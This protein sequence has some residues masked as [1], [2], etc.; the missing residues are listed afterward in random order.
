MLRS[1]VVCLAA[2]F[3]AAHHSPAQQPTLKKKAAAEQ[4]STSSGQAQPEHGPR[5]FSNDECAFPLAIAGSPVSFLQHANNATSGNA[6]QNNPGCQAFGTRR[7]DNDEWFL[8]RANA[9]GLA[10][11]SA[12]P[13]GGIIDTKAAVWDGS[14]CP[15]TA[16]LGCNDD[17]CGTRSEVGFDCIAGRPYLIQIGL[18]PGAEPGTQSWTVFGPVTP[19]GTD[20]CAS[21]TFITG[22]SGTVAT[23]TLAATNN[24]AD[25]IPGACGGSAS[26]ADIWFNYVA[27]NCGVSTFSFCSA[28]LG[29]ATYDTALEVYTDCAGARGQRIACNDDACGFSSSVTFPT[30]VGVSYRIRVSGFNGNV[31]QGTLGWQLLP[32]AFLNGTDDCASGPAISGD[33]ALFTG[34]IFSGN[35]PSDLPFGACFPGSPDRW[36]TYF[37]NSTGNATFS[38]CGGQRGCGSWDTVLAAYDSCGGA[39]LVCNDDSCGLP[40]SI[41]V[42]VVVG[43]SYRIRLAGFNNLTGTGV[44]GWTSPTA[45]FND[46]CGSAVAVTNGTF[47]FTTIGATNDFSGSCGTTANSPDVW[48]RYN[49]S[50]TGSARVSTCGLTDLDT[51]LVAMNSCGGPE[52]TCLDDF[53][54]L[55]TTITFPVSVGQQ[56]LVRVAGYTLTTGSGQIQFSCFLPCPCDWNNDSSLNSQDLFDFLTDFFVGDADFNQSGST[57][58]QDFFD[59]LTCIF[60]GCP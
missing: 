60:A 8:W 41:V 30:A 29:S 13:A 21:A 53:C 55:Q 22:D 32:S 6:G 18:F 50:C 42:P 9:T 31:G 38:F 56:Y 10:T 49:A 7:I 51:V 54:G 11:L 44:L 37:A 58:S 24:L 48:F 15:P 35:T 12:C 27:G 47:D 26:T 1:A 14:T 33:G 34:N 28:E 45:P 20:D 17:G 46:S 36:F 52:I 4:V 2:T 3:A 59:F 23:S 16:L 40:S 25:V 19:V 43:R 57:D 39:Q 5:G